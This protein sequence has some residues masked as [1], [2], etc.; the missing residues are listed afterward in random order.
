VSIKLNVT[1]EDKKHLANLDIEVKVLGNLF[2]QRR[3][4]LEQKAISIL[5]TNSLSPKLY[6]ITFNVAKDEY[7]AILKPGAITIPAP[8]TNINKI[9]TN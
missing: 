4:M 1:D 6:A 7:E 5:E 8:G 9:K 3:A 2:N